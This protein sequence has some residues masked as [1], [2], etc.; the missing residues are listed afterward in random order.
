MRPFQTCDSS[1]E[2]SPVTPNPPFK[3]NDPAGVLVPKICTGDMK[4]A[5]R[6][7][8]LSGKDWSAVPPATVTGSHKSRGTAL[9]A[10]P[11]SGNVG[12]GPPAIALNAGEAQPAPV[13]MSEAGATV[14]DATSP[15]SSQ[16]GDSNVTFRPLTLRFL[17]R[18]CVLWA[19]L[20]DIDADCAGEETDEEA[21]YMGHNRWKKCAWEMYRNWMSFVEMGKDS[22]AA[23]SKEIAARW[24][25]GRAFAAVE[26]SAL[27]RYTNPLEMLRGECPEGCPRKAWLRI[28]LDIIRESP[29]PI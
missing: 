16:G 12:A 20:L 23:G 2:V 17:W 5:K 8:L 25:S 4:P 28:I 13:S 27:A 22:V 26:A 19:N 18:R 24:P 1:A 7:R 3:P 9:V 14:L 11:L 29:D 15:S 6:P 21:Q 10:V